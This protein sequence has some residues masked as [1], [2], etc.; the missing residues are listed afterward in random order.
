MNPSPA[1]PAY[2]ATTGPPAAMYTGT[3]VLGLVVHRGVDGLVV[4]AVEATPRPRST[5][6]AS[7]APPR[8]A[9]RTGSL[10]SGHSAPVTA[11]SFS[12]SPVPSP[13][14]I[15]SGYRHAIVAKACAI[16]AGLY[17]NVAVST[18]V[19]STTRAVRSPTAA[20]Q[21][22]RERRVPAR[23]AA[24]AGSGPTPTRCRARPPRPAPRTPPAPAAR[25]APPTPCSRSAAV[26]PTPV[27]PSRRRAIAAPVGS[28]LHRPALHRER[29]SPR[30]GT[31][32]RAIG[33]RGSVECPD[34]A[35]A[36]HYLPLAPSRPDALALRV[37]QRPP[38]D[39]G[40]HPLAVDLHLDRGTRADLRRAAARR[41]STGRRCS[42]SR[43]T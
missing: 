3:G 17:R 42:R 32:W 25:T 4:L 15:R 16:T 19:P 21:R 33:I 6:A 40:G 2:F 30:V 12:A 7:A 39:L 34:R 14:T 1:R 9:G 38:D 41:R 11:V 20:M 37:V 28:L 22:Q 29:G 23:R 5:A 35:F 27:L 43:P 36:R 18:L 8:A 24:T 31:F 10:K 13:S 26:A